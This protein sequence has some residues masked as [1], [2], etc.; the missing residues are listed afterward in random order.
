[1]NEIR[2]NISLMVTLTTYIC[3]RMHMCNLMKLLNTY[4]KAQI[5]TFY[6][7][8]NELVWILVIHSLHL[9]N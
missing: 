4:F 7:I 1:M 5:P 8:R 9:F 6:I 2:F 3:K